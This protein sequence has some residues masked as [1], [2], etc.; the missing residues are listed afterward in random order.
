MRKVIY[1]CARCGKTTYFTHAKGTRKGSVMFP[2]DWQTIRNYDLCEECLPIFHKWF[3]KF[4]F[5]SKK[6]K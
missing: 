4:L 6:E 2:Y 1:T 5:E 3:E